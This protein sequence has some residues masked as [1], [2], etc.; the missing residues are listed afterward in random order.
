MN[1]PND[2]KMCLIPIGWVRS[3]WY[4]PGEAPTQGAESDAVSM[5]DIRPEFKAALDGLEEEHRIIVLTWLHLSDRH[6]LRVHPR[7]DA[8]RPFRGVFATRSPARPNPIGLHLVTLVNV[9]NLRLEVRGMDALDGTPI[10]DIKPY[11][12][13]LDDPV[14]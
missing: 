5:L 6:L 9:S 12:Q 3:C 11:R 1:A 13:R 14:S 4:R 8:S 7:G 10:L 2:K